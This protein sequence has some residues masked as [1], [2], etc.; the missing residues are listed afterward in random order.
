[1]SFIYRW[2]LT[3][4]GKNR[5]LV[6]EETEITNCREREKDKFIIDCSEER[7][8][9]WTKCAGK[10]REVL[11]WSEIIVTMES[12]E[13]E[14]EKTNR[15]VEREG[16]GVNRTT[17][18]LNPKPL[19]CEMTRMP[20]FIQNDLTAPVAKVVADWLRTTCQHARMANSLSDNWTLRD[21]VTVMLRALL[22]CKIS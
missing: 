10:C 22:I 16:G 20:S 7:D 14:R 17:D 8:I 11:F 15:H 5:G 3:S 4:W 2:S 9:W 12:L 1:M 21:F 18:F 13:R 6:R 19:R